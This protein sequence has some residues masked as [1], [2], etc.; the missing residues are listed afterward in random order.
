MCII[1]L[2]SVRYIKVESKIPV[3]IYWRCKKQFTSEKS[4][5]LF[6][7]LTMKDIKATN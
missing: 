6:K 4:E 3:Q 7:N 1:R 2:L 5:I